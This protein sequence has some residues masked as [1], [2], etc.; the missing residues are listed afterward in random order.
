MLCNVQQGATTLVGK[1]SLSLVSCESVQKKKKKKKQKTEA[2]ITNQQVMS[3]QLGPSF[4]YRLW[5][6]LTGPQGEFKED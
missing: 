2:C 5:I 6:N 3:Q 4:R 1:Q